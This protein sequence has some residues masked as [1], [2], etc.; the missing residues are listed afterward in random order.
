MS[1]KMASL[2]V[3]T[4]KLNK[5][6]RKMYNE[7]GEGAKNGLADWSQYALK[8]FVVSRLSGGTGALQR[9]RG[10]LARS[11]R[12]ELK[13]TGLESQSRFVTSSRYARIQ[14]EGGKIVPKHAKALAIPVRG[15]PAMTPSGVPRYPSGAGISLRSTLPKDHRFWVMK[16]ANG[17]VWLMGAKQ[18]ASGKMSRSKKGRAQAWFQ[19]VKSVMLKP[20]MKFRESIRLYAKVFAARL[21]QTARKVFGGQ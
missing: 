12:F 15:G 18:E 21:A 16:S 6:L 2:Q 17:K 14:E 20:R 8:R 1:E 10:D 11:F 4:D 19:L 3:A 5:A 13:G 9:R 7:F